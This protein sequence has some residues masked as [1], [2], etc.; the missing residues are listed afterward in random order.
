MKFLSKNVSESEYNVSG[1]DLL[2]NNLLSLG[3]TA[4][5]KSGET[6]RV[7]EKAQP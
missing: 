1:W 4:L 7:E 3:I 5:P 6:R 2:F